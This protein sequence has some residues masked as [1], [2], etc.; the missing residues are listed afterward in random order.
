MDLKNIPE[1]RL[2]QN[3]YKTPMIANYFP[4]SIRVKE[5]YQYDVKFEEPLQA[6][7]PRFSLLSQIEKDL[8][9]FVYDGFSILYMMQKIP[10][11]EKVVPFRRKNVK[12]IIKLTKVLSSDDNDLQPFEQLYNI[13]FGRVMNC[14]DFQQIRRNYYDNRNPVRNDQ[15][16]FELWHGFFHAIYKTKKG[17]SLNLDLIHKVVRQDTVLDQI[18]MV[19]SFMSDR[20]GG[21]YDRDRRSP[22]RIDYSNPAIQQRIVEEVSNS[23]VM[24]IYNNK[25]YSVTSVDFSKSPMF[26]FED[27]RKGT[28]ITLKDYY[29]NQYHKNIADPDQ[30]LLVVERKKKDST[31]RPIREEIYLIPELCSMTGLTNSMREDRKLMQSLSKH[32]HISPDERCSRLKEF[33][34]TILKNEKARKIMDEW[35]MRID[36]NVVRVE[37]RILDPIKVFFKNKVHDGERPSWDGLLKQA[38][39]I[40]PQTFN[41]WMIVYPQ[42]IDR[43]I[44]GFLNALIDVGQRM[45]IEFDPNKVDLNSVRYP[46]AK[47]YLEQLEKLTPEYSLVICVLPRQQKSK[48]DAIKQI[49]TLHK[50][51]VSQCILANNLRRSPKLMSI[52]TKIV[53]QIN[54]KAGGSLWGIELPKNKEIMFCGLDVC[55]DPYKR[56]QSVAGFVSS[57]NHNCTNFYS[58]VI[59]QKTKEELVNNLASFFFEGIKMYRLKNDKVAPKHIMVFRDGVGDSQMQ[60]VIE[61]E[62]PAIFEAFKKTPDSYQR[63]N[64]TFVV[65]QKRIKT[66]IFEAKNGTYKNPQPGTVVDLD[67][68]TPNRFDF[69]HDSSICDIL[70][71]IT[72]K[73]CHLYYNWPGPVRVPAVCQYAHKLSFLVGQSIHQEVHSHLH[74]KLYF[75]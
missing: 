49:I 58:R 65:V 50:P 34:Q 52:C 35:G 37:G 60:Y 25:Y 17:L 75:L 5:I 42:S 57:T 33:V 74:D 24:T 39:V 47:N 61:N 46:E 2:G 20:R 22:S 54:C 12:V 71:Q 18:K 69:L 38:T 27:A 19:V 6:I 67:I 62:I 44:D 63:P 15:F 73:L 8:G 11:Y 40:S 3:G 14:L 21:G 36:P 41:R 29:A 68:T 59:M 70:Q 43:D 7:R 30:P 53:M 51:V 4:V 56:S 26:S 9:S 23:V 31:G 66:R 45:G 32:L 64:V 48:Y 72:F 28:K 1:P 10:D 55:H 16:H 13:I